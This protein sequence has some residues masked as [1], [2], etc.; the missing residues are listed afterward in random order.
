[1]TAGQHKD[2]TTG[3]LKHVP[4]GMQYLGIFVAPASWEFHHTKHF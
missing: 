1:M 3:V 2:G 4:S